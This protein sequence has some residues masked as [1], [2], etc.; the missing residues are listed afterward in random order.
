MSGGLYMK[1][2]KSITIKTGKVEDFM[3][4][5]KSV[6][7]ALDK[8]EPLKP[9]H[10]LTFADPLEMLQFLSET[11]LKLINSIRRHPDS[12]SNIAKAIKRDRAAVFRDIKEME[13]FGLV[14]TYEEINPGHGRHKMVKVAANKLKLEAYI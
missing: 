14:K 6:M 4:H 10:T 9:S 3:A 7:R 8:K 5:V 1:K 11:K 2:L 13:K 12:I